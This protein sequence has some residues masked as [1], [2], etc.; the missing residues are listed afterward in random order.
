VIRAPQT[1]IR[2]A[3]PPVVTCARDFRAKA[4]E[5]DVIRNGRTCRRMLLRLIIVDLW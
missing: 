2:R 5:K 4:A 3:R 1:R